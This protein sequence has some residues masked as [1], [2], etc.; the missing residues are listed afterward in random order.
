VWVA[1]DSRAGGAG[2][3]DLEIG[4]L[5]W[6]SNAFDHPPSV[7]FPRLNTLII[8]RT[9]GARHN[10]QW[11]WRWWLMHERR[12]KKSGLI[13]S[14]VGQAQAKAPTGPWM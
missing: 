8:G 14:P 3:R 13:Y 12:P 11:W 5:A 7:P 4:Q 1:L 10:Q 9:D 6:V 2:G